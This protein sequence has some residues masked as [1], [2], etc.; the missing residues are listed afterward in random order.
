MVTRPPAESI[1]FDTLVE[2]WNG[3]FKNRV[4]F[5]YARCEGCGVLF[6]PTFFDECQLQTLYKQMPPNMEVIP[7]NALEKTQY[8]YFKKLRKHSR[9]EGEYIE[10]GPDIGLFTRYCAQ[11]GRFS[12][13]WLFE[14]NQAVSPALQQAVAGKPSTIIHDMFGIAAAPDNSAGAAVLIHVLDHLLNPAD[15]LME[16]RSKLTADGVVLIVTHNESSVLRRLFGPRW[17]PFCLQHPELYNPK[18]MRALMSSTG[19]EVVEIARTINYFPV[20][21]LAR[22]LLWALGLRVESVPKIFGLTLGLKLGNMITI[23]KPLARR[24]A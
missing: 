19:F 1:A 13:Y 11:L 17:P 24:L 3:L 16:I 2:H 4:F 8:G 6:A 18:S 21:F 5:S 20:Q 23:A 22:S 12:R 7:K 9:L 14:P 15:V 10:V